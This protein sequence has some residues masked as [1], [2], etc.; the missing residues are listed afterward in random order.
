MTNLQ[1]LVKQAVENQQ[2]VFDC[3]IVTQWIDEELDIS[4]NHHDV[5]FELDSMRENGTVEFVSR[6]DAT[7]YRRMSV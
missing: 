1:N 3:M 6:G 4:L 2:E 5:A 7:K